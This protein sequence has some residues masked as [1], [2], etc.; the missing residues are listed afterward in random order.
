MTMVWIA[1]FGAAGTLCRYLFGRWVFVITGGTFP[2]G[3]F[4][5]NVVGCLL[6]GIVA[7]S[8]GKGALVSPAV[9]LAIVVGFL[10]GFTTFSSF[11]FESCSLVQ[12]HNWVTACGYVLLSN[13]TGLAAVWLGHRLI[14]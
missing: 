1:V 12:T 4:A 9:R 10:G 7:G 8:I 2:W 5:V 13:V 11:A 14:V 3:T 6:I